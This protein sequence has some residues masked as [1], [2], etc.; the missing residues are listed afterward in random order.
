MRKL[1]F[2]LLL[3]GLTGCFKK[4][5]H[6]YQTSYKTQG[7]KQF[8]D[9]TAADE[10]VT[11]KEA[12]KKNIKYMT[13]PE[14]RAARIYYEESGEVE[15]IEKALAHIIKLSDN[16]QEKADC[17]YELAT[18]QLSFGR[19]EK[20]RELFEQLI[21][22]YP[23]VDFKKEARYRHI[24]AHYW[25]CSDAQHDQEMTE[26][27]LKLS[28]EFLEEFPGELEYQ[29]SLES[30]LDFCH[31][32][33]F[34]AELLRMNFY[35]SKYELTKEADTLRSAQKR[36][37]YILEKLIE[38][39]KQFDSATKDNLLDLYLE[40]KEISEENNIEKYTKL[41]NAADILA[42]KPK[43]ETDEN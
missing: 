40:I 39:Q 31:K 24:L 19:L 16:Y 14:V 20:A 1:S 25:D 37:G 18:I 41:L 22:E 8:Y 9:T 43:T 29:E 11:P 5:Y 38:Q 6:T 2:V 42:I 34:D 27:T 26:K 36:L 13:L 10:E 7:A 17:L 3:L 33:L 35:L 4:P 23:G 12:V 15:I 32:M 21:R 28:K 30:I